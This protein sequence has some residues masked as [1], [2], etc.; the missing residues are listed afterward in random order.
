MKGAIL[1]FC[2]G[3]SILEDSVNLVYLA[4]Q[5]RES[6]VDLERMRYA[7]ALTLRFSLV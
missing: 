3:S 6:A 1:Q 2:L 4:T 7:L 5:G